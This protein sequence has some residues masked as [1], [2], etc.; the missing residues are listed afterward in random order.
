V[1]L[2]NGKGNVPVNEANAEEVQTGHTPAY[3][4]FRLQHVKA[5]PDLANPFPQLSPQCFGFSPERL[6]SIAVFQR[7]DIEATKLRF[8]L[9]QL[10][11]QMVVSL[12][13]FE[14]HESLHT[15]RQVS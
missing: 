5:L 11:K 15:Y 2:G 10:V 8:R 4:A 3:S 13:S 14:G 6:A 12:L 9:I 7:A 1:T